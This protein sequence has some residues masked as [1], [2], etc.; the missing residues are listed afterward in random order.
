MTDKYTSVFDQ[1]NSKRY[2]IASDVDETVVDIAPKLAKEMQ[3]RAWGTELIHS[4]IISSRD[5]FCLD[6]AIP[7]LLDKLDITITEKNVL[8]R[9]LKECDSSRVL[10][11]YKDLDKTMYDDLELNTF[12][13][14]LKSI[15]FQISS[16]NFV[17]HSG[18]IGTCSKSKERF[19]NRN[20]GD[21]N[22]DTIKCYPINQTISKSVILNNIDWD[23]YFDDRPSIFKD[24]ITKTRVKDKTLGV[25]VHPYSTT[26]VDNNSSPI[27]NSL[28]LLSNTGLFN[29]LQLAKP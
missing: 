28:K 15:S 13:S 14:Y 27:L 20:F 22:I 4:S 18:D 3:L 1:D 9:A 2:N 6:T 12:G 26:E 11:V 17:T 16:L 24:I 10:K 29:L 25:I 23:I 5:T 7:K 21:L 8:R 19:L